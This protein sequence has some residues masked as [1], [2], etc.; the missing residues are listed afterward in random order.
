MSRYT[1]T[2]AVILRF[3]LACWPLVLDEASS[4]AWADGFWKHLRERR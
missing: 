1:I 3:L 4:R 2:Y